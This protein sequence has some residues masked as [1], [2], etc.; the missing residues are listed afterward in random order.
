M[1]GGN[2]FGTQGLGQSTAYQPPPTIATD[3]APASDSATSRGSK[4]NVT[5]SAP[6]SDAASA[7]AFRRNVTDDASIAGESITSV[8]PARLSINDVAP[9]FDSANLIR[10]SG[11]FTVGHSLVGGTE[12]LNYVRLSFTTDSAPASDATTA[13]KITPAQDGFRTIT[14]TTPFRLGVSFVGSRHTLGV[15]SFGGG[16]QISGSFPVHDSAPA[17]DYFGAYRGVNDSAPAGDAVTH[18]VVPEFDTFGYGFFGQGTFSQLVKDS[19][20]PFIVGVSRVGHIRQLGGFFPHRVINDYAHASDVA[21]VIALFAAIADSAPASDAVF[22][23]L[24]QVIDSAP[25]SDAVLA[26]FGGGQIALDIAYATDEV[27]VAIKW[28]QVYED[29]FVFDTVIVSPFGAYYLQLGKALVL[30]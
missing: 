18:A 21:R 17:T 28:T 20:G 14:S 8:G 6:A 1:F 25:A 16:L 23:N 15:Y 19:T 26:E 13:I 4:K 5:D 7:E 9:A 29:V 3:S 2:I 22:I 10:P 24:Q 12:S 30:A 11:P 27:I